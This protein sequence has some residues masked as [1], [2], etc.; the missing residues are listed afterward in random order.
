MEIIKRWLQT[1]TFWWNLFLLLIVVWL[2]VVRFLVISDSESVHYHAD[3]KLYINSQAQLLDDFS[4]YEE[5]SACSLDSQGKPTS[6][7]HLHDNI[8][9]VIHVHD[10]AVTYGHFMSNLGFHLSDRVLE[11]RREVYVDGNG[12]E[13]R[14]I[15]NGQPFHYLSRRV[16]ESEDVLLIDFSLDEAAVLMER[17][18][19]IPRQAAAA[20]QNQDPQSC[21]GA[22]EK[23][24]L[25]QSFQKA[26][27]F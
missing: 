16:I 23:A 19:S 14:F 15:L 2:I 1:K 25:W 11:T 27:G 3:F 24:S 4:F 10:R 17:Y 8:P 22:A 5:I 9:S 18:Q 20:N 12:G 26:L 6:R 13:L 7:A 21:A